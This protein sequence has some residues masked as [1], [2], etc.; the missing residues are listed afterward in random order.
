MEKRQAR[1]KMGRWARENQVSAESPRY[2]MLR[3]SNKG[4]WG[5]PAKVEIVFQGTKQEWLERY[6][7]AKESPGMQLWLEVGTEG[8]TLC[9][10]EMYDCRWGSWKECG[11]P[12]FIQENN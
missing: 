8:T 9:F 6:P 11:D 3:I 7:P 4:K 1:S 12:R 10:R 5:S 2:L